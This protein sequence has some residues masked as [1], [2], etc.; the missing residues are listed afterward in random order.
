MLLSNIL[1]TEGEGAPQELSPVVK[2]NVDSLR[3]LYPGLE[4]RLFDRAACREIIEKNFDR[5]VLASFDK[6]KPGAYQS[7]LARLCILHSHGGIY[8]DLSVYFFARWPPANSAAEAMSIRKLAVFRDFCGV[9]PWQVANTVIF[10]PPGHPAIE[11]AIDLIC[12]NVKNEFY[13]CSS[14]SPTGPDP[15]GKAIALS[16]APEDLIT[17]DSLFMLPEFGPG[18]RQ[19]ITEPSHCFV[20]MDRL[21]AAKRKRGEG[22]SELGIS[23]GNHYN[24][25]WLARDVYRT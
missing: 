10:A 19:V 8:A 9:A 23:G 11:K 17:G 1:I 5:E 7:D 21:I 6:L 20:F 13:G 16:A 2:E 25:M 14:L 3:A 12:I 15:F 4:Y 24:A 18:A 22:L